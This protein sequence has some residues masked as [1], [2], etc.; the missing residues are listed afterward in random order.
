M[1]CAKGN[2]PA[3]IQGCPFHISGTLVRWSQVAPMPSVRVGPK[4]ATQK[5]GDTTN[6][7]NAKTCKKKQTNKAT[8]TAK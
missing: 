7:Q 8:E 4:K 1:L 6:K 2:Q 3:Q 5:K